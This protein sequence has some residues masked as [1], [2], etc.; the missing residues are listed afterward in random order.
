MAAYLSS[1]AKKDY[2]DFED[3]QDDLEDALSNMSWTTTSD[4]TYIPKVLTEV[5]GWDASDT[6]VVVDDF[7]DALGIKNSALTYATMYNSL[8]SLR[9]LN[10]AETVKYGLLY[11]IDGTVDV[12]KALKQLAGKI[13][14]M[15]EQ[16]PNVNVSTTA[17]TRYT[18]DYTVSVSVVNK[19]LGV[20]DWYSGSANFIAVTVTRV[21]TAA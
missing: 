18:Y 8:V 13:E 19:S 5:H 20:I 12:D 10:A 6:A 7:V 14:D 2:I 11:V 4:Y 16:L 21:P 1:D 15:L 3:N 9:D 17:T